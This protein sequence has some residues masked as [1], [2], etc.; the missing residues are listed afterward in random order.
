MALNNID[1]STFVLTALPAG[2]HLTTNSL[3]QLM[4]D[5]L[6]VKF[7]VILRPTVSRP[8]SLGVKPHLGPKTRVL[9]LSVSDLSMWGA[10]SD[11]RTGLS[12]VPVI[13]SS[14]WHLYLQFYLSAF[15]YV[16]TCQKP[17]SLCIH[18]IYS[19]ICNS[20]IYVCT[21]YTRPLSV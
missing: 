17:G 2:Y 12:F 1:S 21:I 15:S 5:C 16:V 10:Y 14:T 11:G 6:Q 3:P 13:V 7:K 9:L 8:V 18:I 19:C 20:S 4:T